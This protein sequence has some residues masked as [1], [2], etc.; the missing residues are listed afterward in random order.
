MT[1]WQFA[2]IGLGGNIGDAPATL[3]F[4]LE[5]LAAHEQ[6]TLTAISPLYRSA[7]IGPAGQPDYAN[8]V[9]TL[10]TSLSPDAL[11]SV[12]QDIEHMAGRE[13]LLRWGART[14]DLD[15]LLYANIT[16]HSPRLTIPHIELCNRAFVLVPLTDITPDL[17]LPGGQALALLTASC[18]RKGLEIWHDAR[19]PHARH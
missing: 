17:I 3:C 1:D 4:A 5:Q 11:L 14:L 12:L 19:W 13:R 9:V 15:L 7:P 10:T 16:M 2:A 6:I 18:S 8:A